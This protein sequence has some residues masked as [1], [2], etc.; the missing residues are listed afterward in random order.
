MRAGDPEPR[1]E[2]GLTEDECRQLAGK[3]VDAVRGK[4][5][6]ALAQFFDWDALLVT[7][8][9]D[10]EAPKSVKDRFAARMQGDA[11]NAGALGVQVLDLVLS[12]ADYKYLRVHVVGN[13]QRL[14]F[15][16][17]MPEMAGL[18]YH[19]IELSRCRDGEIKGVD[20]SILANGEMLS[21]TTR[22]AFTF[23]RHTD[24]RKVVQMSEAVRAGNLDLALQLYD[25]LP[26][27]LQRDKNV[28]LIRLRAAQG[29]GEAQ[30]LEAVQNLRTYHP[31]DPCIDLYGI[32]YFLL[33]KDF[34]RAL[35]MIDRVDKA[36]GDG[37]YM[38]LWRANVYQMAGDWTA[39]R[40]KAEA[41]IA[42]EP[43]LVDAHWILVN[44][45]LHEKKHAETL[46]RLREIQRRFAPKF[47]DLASIPEY[48]E[49]VKSPQ[50]QDWL[51]S[52]QSQ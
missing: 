24:S 15:R 33:K 23:D 13:Q 16:V 43:T 32:T 48:A 42:A 11:K 49:F 52:H 38:N 28:L 39:A 35:E 14:L 46:Q 27:E 19:D 4:D 12:G 45:S 47:P 17:A 25:Q 50:Y 20:V 18:N 10:V 51:K 2:P 9:G 37:S 26:A 5:A 22:R 3:I 1:I 36:V 30:Y 44:V 41:A 8:I 34:A 29:V 40:N 31:D 6:A 21:Q 7:A